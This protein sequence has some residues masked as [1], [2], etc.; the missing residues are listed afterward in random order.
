MAKQCP[1]IGIMTSPTADVERVQSIL[2]AIPRSYDLIVREHRPLAEDQAILDLLFRGR[3]VRTA[4]IYVPREAYQ[5]LVCHKIVKSSHALLIIA[6]KCHN[7]ITQHAA[8]VAKICKR[9]AL[10]LFAG[11]EVDPVTPIPSGHVFTMF[12]KESLVCA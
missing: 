2:N 9:P 7:K 1:S 5:V 10:V 4:P 6:G 11:G 8:A 12:M 3:C